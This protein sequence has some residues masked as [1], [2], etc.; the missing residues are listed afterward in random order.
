MI[1]NRYFFNKKKVKDIDEASD[2]YDSI[3][4]LIKNVEN[5]N[6]NVGT[7]YIPVFYAS[8]SLLSNH[9]ALWF[10]HRL[11]ASDFFF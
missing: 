9:P 2:T 8:Y 5:N 4:W 1:T 11:L 3:D 6:G 7:R 10:R